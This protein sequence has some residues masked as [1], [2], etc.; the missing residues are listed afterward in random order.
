[1]LINLIFLGLKKKSY[2]S[3]SVDQ[4]IEKELVYFT[5]SRLHCLCKDFIILWRI[6]MSI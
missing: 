3:V 5:L 2:M 6:L 1:M 4:L